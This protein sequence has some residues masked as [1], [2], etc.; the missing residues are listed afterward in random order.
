[1]S[2]LLCKDADGAPWELKDFTENAFYPALEKIGI[3]NPLVEIGGGKLRH[4]YTP[5]TCRHTFATL[6]KRVDGA[7]KDK[8]ELIGHA[9]PEMLRYYQDA[10]V[11]DLRR[12]TDKI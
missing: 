10:P 5:H 4:K 7:D 11:D 12:I 1:M 3:D 6:L 8:Q 9:S 2:W